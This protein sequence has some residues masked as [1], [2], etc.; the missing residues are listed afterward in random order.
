MVNDAIENGPT[1]AAWSQMLEAHRCK[2]HK[3]Q[4]PEVT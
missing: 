4:I 1:T 3:I 2:I